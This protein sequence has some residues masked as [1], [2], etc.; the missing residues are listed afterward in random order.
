MA[1][2]T[3][4][5]RDLLQNER[6]VKSRLYCYPSNCIYRTPRLFSFFQKKTSC[7]TV[8]I[9]CPVVRVL[10]LAISRSPVGI[11]AAAGC[12]GVECNPGQVVYTL[13]PLSPGSITGSSQL[14][15][16]LGGWGGNHVPGRKLMAAYR[17]VYG[18]AHGSAG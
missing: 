6:Y 2:I 16:M 15:F 5:Y 14:A 12:R 3:P 9:G 13:V 11:S 18:F 10:D 7:A 17:L 8:L 1:K 4:V